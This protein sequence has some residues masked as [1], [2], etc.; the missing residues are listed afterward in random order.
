VIEQA[1][2]RL[3]WLDT[4]VSRECEIAEARITAIDREGLAE[5]VGEVGRS[6][7]QPSS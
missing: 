3:A 7:V 1:F 6:D 5:F 4:T 2:V